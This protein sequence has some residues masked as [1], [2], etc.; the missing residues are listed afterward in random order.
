MV[1]KEANVKNIISNSANRE[2]E[3]IPLV[4]GAPSISEP[5]TMCLAPIW[6]QSNPVQ[7]ERSLAIEAA[8]PRTNSKELQTIRGFGIGLSGCFRKRYSRRLS[9]RK[10]TASASQRLAP[11]SRRMM[12]ETASF[13]HICIIRSTVLKFNVR[14]SVGRNLNSW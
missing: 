4:A 10:L 13:N 8:F 6:A 5:Q 14:S 12:I 2:K 9:R 3:R 11:G 1:I 7:G